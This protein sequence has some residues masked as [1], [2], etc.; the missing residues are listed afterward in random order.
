MQIDWFTVGAQI[1]NFLVLVWLLK[2]FLYRPITE[3][4]Q[5]REDVIEARLH[6]AEL[7]R[8]AA[9]K[10]IRAYEEKQEELELQKERMLSQAGEAADEERKALERQ[11]REDIDARRQEWLNQLQTQKEVFLQ[12][13][14]ERS[15]DEF[16]ALATRALDD[17]GNADLENQ[18]ALGFIRR[19]ENLTGKMKEEFAKECSA[20]G[21]RITVSSRFPLSTNAR[22]RITAAIH[23]EL[24]RELEPKYET[25]E[26]GSA[27]LELKA[28]NLTVSWGFE[29]YLDGLRKAVEEQLSTVLAIDEDR[30]GE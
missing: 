12:Q 29:S 4:M 2:R 13:L 8:E 14:S 10:E 20:A 30:A 26:E 6:E 16:Y 23:R 25:R 17:L 3:A 1:V 24:G 19:L 7:A 18:M 15:T 5:R 21:A 28:G 27:G 22:R 9:Q 11:A